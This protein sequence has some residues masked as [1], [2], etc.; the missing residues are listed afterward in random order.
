[1]PIFK[2]CLV[3]NKE[4]RT[5]LSKIKEGNGKFCS[6][7]CYHFSDKGRQRKEY[8]MVNCL[9]CQKQFRTFPSRVKSNL[10]KYCCKK[11]SYRR[12]EMFITWHGYVYILKPSHPQSNKRGYVLE[13]RLVCEKHLN[14]F[15]EPQ[16]H[17]HHIN[18]IRNDNRIENLA[19]FKN[20]GYHCAFHRWKYLDPKTILLNL[21]L[22]K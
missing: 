8:L 14:R 15:L 11:C 20:K 18:E 22:L 21:S 3:C 7:K 19:V 17:V 9:R 2:N 13:H 5:R 6:R 10:S 1:M 4:F 16:E 12:K